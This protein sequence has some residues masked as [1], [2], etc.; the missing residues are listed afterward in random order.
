MADRPEPPSR[1]LWK[2][3]K[4]ES[5]Q[6]AGT[7]P[8][9]IV[10]VGFLDEVRSMRMALDYLNAAVEILDSPEMREARYRNDREE[11]RVLAERIRSEC[12]YIVAMFEN[13]AEFRKKEVRRL[14]EWVSKQTVRLITKPHAVAS[15]DAT[16]YHLLR[17]HSGLSRML[18]DQEKAA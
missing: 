14:G 7:Y 18:N 2:P 4:K 13:R 8:L 3:P 6:S 15:Y 10:A 11:L 17:F 5:F 16:A 12:E 9:S 1:P